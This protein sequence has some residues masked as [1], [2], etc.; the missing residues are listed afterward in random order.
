MDKQAVAFE[1]QFDGS[2]FLA[3]LLLSGAPA[4]DL[5]GRENARPAAKQFAYVAIGKAETGDFVLMLVDRS[6]AAYCI[7]RHE[8][9]DEI[10]AEWLQ[11]AKRLGLP[12]YCFVEEGVAVPFD[13][14]TQEVWPRRRAHVM[15]KRRPRFLATRK[16]PVL[17][18]A[19][20]LR[21]T[22]PDRR[23]QGR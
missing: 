16:Q 20:G 21:P 22:T 1:T 5:A 6:G 13:S 12:R 10:Y 7:A 14:T 9:D 11:V 17:T 8:T 4:N 3:Q 15:A 2:N 19:N 23:S 18:Y